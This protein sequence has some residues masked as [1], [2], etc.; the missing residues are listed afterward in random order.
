MD[1]ARKILLVGADAR[2]H[3]FL[4]ALFMADGCV[5]VALPP[6]EELGEYAVEEGADLVVV[7]LTNQVMRILEL[8]RMFKSTDSTRHIPVLAIL[9]GSVAVNRARLFEFGV[10]DYVIR[11][12]DHAELR[13]RARVAIEQKRLCDRLLQ[14]KEN[15]EAERAAAEAAAKARAD[16]LASMS[17]EI[18]TPMNGVIAMASL[19]LETPLTNEQRGY[20]ETIRSCGDSLLALINDI[21]DLSK[22]DSGQFE[23][24]REPFEL[25]QCIEEALDVLA[26]KA[27][28]KELELSYEIDESV[29]PVVKG[30]VTRIRQILVNLIGNAVKFTNQGEVVVWV[31]VVPEQEYPKAVAGKAADGTVC[32]L[33]FAV[34]DTGIGIPP[35]KLDKLFKPFS[36]VHGGLS[37]QYGGSGLGL[38]ISKRMVEQMGGQMWVESQPNQGSTF[39]FILPFEVV[40]GSPPAQVD[41]KLPEL[42]GKR[43]LIVDDNPTNRRILEFQTA[44]WGMLPQ[45]VASG[46]EALD[47]LRAG[48]HFDLALLDLRMPEMDGIELAREIRRLPQCAT[49]PIVLVT[50][51]NPPRPDSPELAG[52]NLAASVT[53]P[54]KPAMLQQVLSQVVVVSKPQR[55]APQ[56]RPQPMPGTEPKLA[57]IYP[58]RILIAEDNLINQKVALKL[59]QQLGYSAD[60][61]ANGKEVLAAIDR[62]RYDLVFM[63]V[64]MPEMDGFEATRQIRHRQNDPAKYPNYNPPITIIAMTAI[65]MAGDRERCLNAG[66]D[67]YLAKPIKPADVKAMIE[68]WGPVILE[69]MPE[70]APAETESAT[71]TD[72]QVAQPAPAMTGP[73]PRSQTTS[74]QAPQ[75]PIRTE[76]EPPP[77]PEIDVDRL[78]TMADG[79]ED[80]LRELVDLYLAQTSEQMTKL[81]DAIDQGDGENIYRLAHTMVGASAT[82]GLVSMVPIMREIE[83][84]GRARQLADV[85]A[86]FAKGVREFEAIKAYFS[87]PENIRT[88]LQTASGK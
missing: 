2:T 66:M 26:P 37:R 51:I 8:V 31:R 19:L 9:D 77:T 50:S 28:E 64:L 87:N 44:R 53:K 68:K 16:F 63:D 69:N 10:T 67:D 23:F 39:F 59:L 6:E 18:R 61:A 15:A 36:Q 11:P 4:A 79:A 41:R 43:V 32:L 42:T 14:E 71:A 35:D 5:T 72:T 57:D 73:G 34:R 24:A 56:P 52:L 80:M 86:L 81:R 54:I 85:P 48:Q 78:V 17:H 30:D 20:V 7:V 55:R 88:L 74:P 45:S 40:S 13:A 84:L 38:A 75:A 83:K 25:R 46:P 29:P 1:E 82:L 3:E 47:L 60:V 21:L 62:Q 58:M 12:F 27:A 65:A 76:P 22:I 70:A 49:L 33:Q